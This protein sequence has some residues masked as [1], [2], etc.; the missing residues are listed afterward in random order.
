MSRQFV[1]CGT[2]QF[3]A[4]DSR[5]SNRNAQWDTPPLVRFNVP[6]ANGSRVAKFRGVSHCDVLPRNG[7]ETNSGTSSHVRLAF[8]QRNK[9]QM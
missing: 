8:S 4:S 7:I 1:K 9:K 3:W 2:Q 6:A 5:D